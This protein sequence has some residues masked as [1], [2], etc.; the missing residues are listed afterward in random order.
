[1]KKLIGL[2]CLLYSSS[3]FA[4]TIESS[5]YQ[6]MIIIADDLM[7]D[8]PAFSFSFGKSQNDFFSFTAQCSIFDKKSSKTSTKGKRVYD[9]SLEYHNGVTKQYM[10][11]K[12][13]F[14][15]YANLDVFIRDKTFV[16]VI[17]GQLYDTS[18]NSLYTV[19][20]QTVVVNKDQMSEIRNG[21]NPQKNVQSKIDEL[22][23]KK[24]YWEQCL[25]AKGILKDGQ[26]LINE[27]TAPF[28]SLKKIDLK[29]ISDRKIK[30]FNPK[31]TE[32]KKKYYIETPIPVDKTIL[33]LA[34]NAKVGIGMLANQIVHFSRLKNKEEKSKL[35][36]LMRISSLQ[37]IQKLE[38]IVKE[39]CN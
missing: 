35:R 4:S 10:I 22:K 23:E 29:T 15:T 18:S 9:I 24:Q 17:D 21:C 11:S 3:I 12:S 38:D 8:K 14:D 7:N 2:T 36:D 6:P 25:I 31:Y 37:S 28:E 34:Y 16:F 33:H 32:F 13:K 30:I 39:K 1:M 19:D 27:L 5:D 26:K 20:K